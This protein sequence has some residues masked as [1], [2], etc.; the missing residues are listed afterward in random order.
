MWYGVNMLPHS[1]EISDLT[2]G[3][4]FGLNFSKINWKLGWKNCSAAFGSV[5]EPWTRLLEKGVLKQDL[6][7]IEATTFVGANNFRN[8]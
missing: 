5:S 8:I 4:I 7:G 1:P 2:K 3:D 6:P